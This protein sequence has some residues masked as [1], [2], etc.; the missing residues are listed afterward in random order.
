MLLT[1]MEE[2]PG[3]FQGTMWGGQGRVQAEGP[4]GPRAH[5]HLLGSVAGV[6]WGSWTKARNS[7]SNP[8]E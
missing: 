6:L 1:V 8:K 2:A 7:N 5:R 3:M 4:T